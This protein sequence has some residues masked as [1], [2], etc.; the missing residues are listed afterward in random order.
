[1]TGVC[2]GIPLPRVVAL[3]VLLAVAAVRAGLSVWPAAALV[4]AVVSLLAA[5]PALSRVGRVGRLLSGFALVARSR[6][7]AA[8]CLGWLALARL[9]KPLAA[10]ASGFAL[11]LDDPLHEALVLIPALAFGRTLPFMGFAAGAL[12]VGA[13]GAVACGAVAPHGS[14]P[15]ASSP[16]GA[17]R[18]ERSPPRQP[19]SADA[20]EPTRSAPRGREQGAQ[21]EKPSSPRAL[22]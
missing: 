1:M 14:L 16:T 12:A 21:R 6:R 4:L 8:A 2:V 7:T 11:G 18:C 10:T 13:T 5:A 3:A 9:A 19:R 22:L 20:T 17:R 15:V